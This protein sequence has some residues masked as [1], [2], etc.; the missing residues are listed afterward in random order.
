VNQTWI[1]N[2]RIVCP[3]ERVG[4]GSIVFGNRIVL[5]FANEDQRP[6][7]A[8]FVDAGGRTLTPG[9]IDVH[10]HG[11]ETF[12]YERSPEDLVQGLQ[13]LPRFGTTSVLPTLYRV[14]CPES[15]PLVEQ[16]SGV[17]TGVRNIHAPGFHLEGPFLALAGAGALTMKV[18]LGFLDEL[19]AA[20]AGRAVAMSI[21]PEVTGI[22][23][24][25]ERLVERN[26]VPFITHT[27]AIAEQ[28]Q[29]AID[30][31]AVHATHFYDVFPVP[32]E[33]D[34]GVRPV[35]AVETILADPRVSVDFICDGVHVHPAAIR[36]ALAAKG[37]KGVV[38]ITDANIGAGLPADIYQT[39]WGYSVRIAEEGAARIDDPN[40]GRHGQLTGSSLTMNVAMANLRRWLKIDDASLWSMGTCNPARLVGLQERGVI[41]ANAVADLVLWNE[42]FTAALT[43]VDGELVHSN[44]ASIQTPKM[45]AH[46]AAL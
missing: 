3:G 42:D 17:L 19:L 44:A 46:H 35:G 45:R 32:E 9:L 1:A 20:C 11:I 41:Q 7:D 4:F 29:A 18:D 25:I 43:W 26:V 37:A 8:L 39:P 30:A 27:R 34:A 22:I 38:A 5:L 28:T 24:V 13:R 6:R 31:G 33:T 36:A 21:S 40:H 23:P 2:A 15:L 12:A 10:T 14:L 16:L